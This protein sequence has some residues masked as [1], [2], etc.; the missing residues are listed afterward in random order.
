MPPLTYVKG[1]IIFCDPLE[2]VVRIPQNLLDELISLM[3]KLVAADDR[4]KEEV[5]GGGTVAEAFKKHRG[6]K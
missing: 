2:G 3:P 1:D 6:G 5:L 4:V